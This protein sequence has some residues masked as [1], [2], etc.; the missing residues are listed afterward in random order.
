VL[1]LG[2]PFPKDYLENGVNL[3]YFGDKHYQYKKPANRIDDFSETEKKKVREIRR[4]AKEHNVRVIIQPGDF[5]DKPRLPDDFVQAI[6][7]EWGFSSFKK[8]RED[9][10]AGKLT[11][12]EF[13]DA[14][15]DYIPLVGTVGNHELFGGSLKTLP[16]TTLGFM[17]S[18]GFMNLVDKENSFTIKTKG[19]RSVV[20]SGLPYDLH[21][22]KDVNNFV[23]KEKKGD[24]DL[25]LI[26][27]ALY[28][29]TLGPE[30]NWLPIDKVYKKTK[31]DITIA[32]HI[33]H[34]FGWIEKDGKIFGNPGALAQ[35]SAAVT[36][37]DRDLYG[38]LIHIAEDGS[39]YVKDLK[40]DCPRSRDLFDLSVKESKTSAE[41]QINAVKKVVEKIDPIKGS[42]VSGLIELIGKNDEVPKEV[43]ELALKV[44]EGVESKLRVV[45]PIDENQDYRIKQI[46]LKNFEAHLDT[47]INITEDGVPYVFIGESSNGKSS[48]ARALYFALE[49]EG[50][51]VGFIRRAKDVKRCEVT[52]VRVD[53]LSVTR[54]VEVKKN[55][56]GTRKTEKNGWIIRYP[57]GTETETNTSALEEIQ[58]LFGF[59]Y[60][61][62]D[63]G[64]KVSL[65]FRKQK[66]PDFFLGFKEKQRA[67][68]V[69]SLYGA[70]YL[71]GAIKELEGKRRSLNTSIS[72]FQTEVKDL[73]KQVE[74]LSSVDE[75]RSLLKEIKTDQEK[76]LLLEGKLEKGESLKE[77]F[78]NAK[79]TNLI[80]TRFLSGASPVIT[81]TSD[82]IT[83]LVEQ[84]SLLER[85]TSVNSRVKDDKSKLNK[86]N[87]FLKSKPFVDDSQELIGDLDKKSTILENGIRLKN[88][89]EKIRSGIQKDDMVIS[90]S[91]TV[92][93]VGIDLKLL[94]EKISILEKMEDKSDNY[95]KDRLL[96]DL[97]KKIDYL[98]APLLT[99]TSVDLIE[100]EKLSERFVKL[101][102]LK[103][104]LDKLN[105]DLSNQNKELKNLNKS[106][107][108]I[109]D[110]LVL[111][112][113][114]QFVQIGDCKIFGIGL[115]N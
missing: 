94:E 3:L 105:L 110:E 34:G 75:A 26:H 95:K 77:S 114:K 112:E 25:F 88:K 55:K 97:L 70:Q 98:A 56:V 83:Q 62:L 38:S 47:I 4:L 104:N 21:L 44:T 6:L 40:L 22:L 20:I 74:S 8:A 36:E 23:L 15:L 96:L 27:E 28:N 108:L 107:E 99:Q 86:I 17:S 85:L 76:L 9:Y 10:E 87:H 29:T 33:H 93:E 43:V 68:L 32:G 73:E 31:A 84:G 18:I 79:K 19:G 113:E 7:E 60:L 12:D 61:Y 11:K 39:I 30:V 58:R 45:Q 69:G 66:E 111:E 90:N 42:E 115:N 81:E 35:Q 101:L 78:N 71:L 16:R 46:R 82:L 2:K 67:K 14:V 51:A 13:A 89:V 102:D 41:N 65:N 64:D 63:E 37:L 57:D 1:E 5:L 50:N 80:L 109:K 48:I 53:D 72:H 59:N 106:L 24:T 100:F 49:N 91:E 92:K 52:L 103:N 54:V